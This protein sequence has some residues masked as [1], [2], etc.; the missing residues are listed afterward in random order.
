MKKFQRAF[1]STTMDTEPQKEIED[2]NVQEIF[3][4]ITVVM[5]EVGL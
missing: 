4:L 3:D 1:S 5:K 2:A